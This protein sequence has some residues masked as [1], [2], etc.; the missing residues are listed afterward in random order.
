MMIKNIFGKIGTSSSR[1]LFSRNTYALNNQVPKYDPEKD[2]YKILE[3][4]KEAT[5]SDVKK[6]YYRLAKEY[7]P[8]SNPGK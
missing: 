1:S 4:S 7:H 3:V 8:D 5:D 2:Y 6:A